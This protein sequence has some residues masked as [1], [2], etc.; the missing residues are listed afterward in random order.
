[1]TTT[2]GAPGARIWIEAARPRTLPA[3]VAPVLVGTAAAEVAPGGLSVVRFLLALTVALTLQ[4]A[5]N[6]ANDYFDGVKG[7][8]TEARTGPRRVVA[9]GLVAPS[10][11]KRAI[12]LTLVVAAL[13]GLALAALVGWELLLVGV[14]A[15]LATLGYSGGS[16]PYASAGLGEVF[17]FVFFGVVA[18]VGSAYVQDGGVT[19]VAVLASLP[20]GCLA[21]A[22]LV[23]NNLRDIPSD[24]EVGKRT[25]AVRLGEPRTRLLYVVLVA[26]AFTGLVPLVLVTGEGWLLA[27]LLA[28]VVVW[29][30]VELVRHAPL[31]P[32]LIAALGHTAQAQLVFALLLTASLLLTGGG[33]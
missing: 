32:R 27:P 8:D 3:A 26:V 22:L 25:L 15:V 23:V 28:I 18:T 14:A 2:S 10:A 5:V 21:T 13:A 30:G 1:M 29:R 24:T 17:V 6:F 7:V 4:V 33:R 19:M 11:M 31:G 9:A 12:A 20:M 16:R